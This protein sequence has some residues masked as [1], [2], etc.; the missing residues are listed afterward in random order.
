[1]AMEN[2]SISV[3]AGRQDRESRASQTNGPE[4]LANVD[5]LT[6]LRDREAILG[7]LSE[8]VSLAN[9]YRDDFS[10]ILLNIDHF[11]EVNERCGRMTG[12]YV[13]KKVAGLIRNNIRDTDISAPYGKDEFIVILPR[14]N[15][16]SS[17]VAAERLRT[18]IE[19]TELTDS[20]GNVFAITVSQGLVGW[21][22]GDDAASL[23][24]RAHEA[25]HRAQEKGRNRVQILL[26]PSL[27]DKI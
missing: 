5:R 14:T 25:L 13:L 8:L 23:I 1:M 19:R 2:T 6:G 9:R 22:R 26:G 11:K 21:E 15:L 10:L 4:E 24:S 12:D 3:R 7:K 20:A 17:W 27:R 16:S 18:M